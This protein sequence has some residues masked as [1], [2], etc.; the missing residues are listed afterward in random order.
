MEFLAK[1]NPQETI[2]EHTDNL[3]RNYNIL[4]TTY[5]DLEI[6]WDMLYI[7]CLYHDLGKINPKF[8]EKI[9]NKNIQSHL[10]NILEVPHSFLSISFLEPNVL[11]EKGFTEIDIKVLATAI[12]YHHEREYEYNKQ[13]YEYQLEEIQKIIHEFDYEKLDNIK[14]SKLSKKYF[15][16]DYIYKR[17]DK[18]MF[19]KY[20]LIKGLLN[21]IDYSA[22]AHLDV[23][24]KNDFLI[25]SLESMMNKWRNQTNAEWNDLQKYMYKHSNEDVIVIAQTGMGKTEAGLLWIGDNKGFFTLP[26]KAAINSIYKRIK[27]NIVLENLEERVGLLHSDTYNEYLKLDDDLIDFEEYFSKTRQLCMPLTICTLDQLF[28]FVYRYRGFELKLATLAYSKVIID[29]VQMYSPDLIAYLVVGLRY[30]QEVGGKFAIMTATLPSFLPEILRQEGI[31]FIIPEEIFI[32]ESFNRHSIKVIEDNLNAEFIVNMYRDNKVLVIVNTVKKAQELYDELEPVVD[33]VDLIHSAFIR[34]D[35]KDKEEAILKIGD[36]KSDECGIWIATQVV[37]A[38]LDID[39][40]LLITELSD[41][42]GLFQRMGRC[43]RKRALEDDIYNCYVFVGESET[44]PSGIGYVID[45]DIF[46]LSK[47]EIIKYNGIISEKDKID[48][49]N[50]VYCIDKIRKT[51]YF[52]KIIETMNYVNN[53]EDYEKSKNEVKYRFRNILTAQVIPQ[54]IYEQNKDLIIESL[55][56]LNMKI[57]NKLSSTEKA[58]LK[59]Q[60][61]IARNRI[62]DLTVN[63]SYHTYVKHKNYIKEEVKISK[64]DIIPVFPC[65]YSRDRGVIILNPDGQRKEI[66]DNFI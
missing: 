48:M 61:N 47:T 46:N 59:K 38:S 23:E 18:D 56:I 21:R 40:D 6:D 12:A 45:K 34:K 43:Y 57:D 32:D 16:Y 25:N 3:I 7:S 52:K 54:V 49:I 65:Q 10:K 11:I 60:R 4:K 14:V 55:N 20:V 19:Y 5:P 39:F 24:Y 44:A 27:D 30:I 22:S 33:K 35:R 58:N 42:N 41:L 66:Q 50:S 8:Q 17:N 26:L 31:E 53:I 62:L 64:H 28:D 36:V 37:E 1:S 13:E 9:G 29:E 15:N 51:N 63:I 2:Q